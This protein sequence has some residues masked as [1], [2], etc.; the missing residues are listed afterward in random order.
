MRLGQAA[1]FV[2]PFQLIH[3]TQEVPTLLLPRRRGSAHF[4]LVCETRGS[5]GGG[6][7]GGGASCGGLAPVICECVCV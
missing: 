7:G 2:V 5:G 4:L 1:L 3:K 6:G